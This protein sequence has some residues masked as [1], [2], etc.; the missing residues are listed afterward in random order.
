M[1]DIRRLSRSVKLGVI[2]SVLLSGF[3]LITE[4]TSWL[5]KQ[6]LIC[7]GRVGEE[8]V[9]T[10]DPIADI[11]NKGGSVS[12]CVREVLRP[13]S[14]SMADVWA[15]VTIYPNEKSEQQLLYVESQ[16]FVAK[17]FGEDKFSDEPGDW[18]SKNVKIYSSNGIL[19]EKS[20]EDISSAVN[21][22]L[23]SESAINLWEVMQTDVSQNY[24]SR[25]ISWY[26]LISENATQITVIG[27]AAAIAWG[28][29]SQINAAT[30][31][32]SDSVSCPD[33]SSESARSRSRLVEAFS[34]TEVRR[35][36]LNLTIIFSVLLSGWCVFRYTNWLRP[37][38]FKCNTYLSEVAP[39]RLKVCFNEILSL[40]SESNQSIVVGVT[41]D[42]GNT[43]LSSDMEFYVADGNNAMGFSDEEGDWAF[44]G[45]RQF[46]SNTGLLIKRSD[47]TTSVWYD[48]VIPAD[49]QMKLWNDV[50]N[51]L[52]KN[53]AV[54]R[55]SITRKITDVLG[56]F[57]AL[58]GAV[59]IAVVTFVRA[60]ELSLYKEMQ[61]ED[62]NLL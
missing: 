52:A 30:C 60:V 34:S 40:P 43:F 32:D 27:L 29:I 17:D 6:P 35:E 36:F 45:Y 57:A 50:K 10:T 28:S 21:S 25:Q 55:L 38:S 42:D 12:F 14:E 22:F 15:G 37:A 9:K 39:G 8:F 5:Q 24:G 16:Y 53:Y 31:E 61:S 2:A 33:D 18:V 49:V 47:V 59:L 19:I 13:Y 26:R 58:G 51:D 3:Y 56:S 4:K 1:S 62:S 7:G 11:E 54:N 44:L 48:T 41:A 23:D 20:Q 46:N